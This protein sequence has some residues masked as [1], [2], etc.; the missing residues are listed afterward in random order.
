MKEATASVMARP[1]VFGAD[2]NRDDNG[3]RGCAM[4]DDISPSRGIG[5]A[6]PH[7]RLP[8]HWHSS[9]H[10]GYRTSRRTHTHPKHKSPGRRVRLPLGLALAPPAEADMVQTQ[11]LARMVRM[12]SL[13]PYSPTSTL[14]LR[15]DLQ[16][17]FSLS[18]NRSLTTFHS[19]GFVLHANVFSMTF[20]STV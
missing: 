12:A 10:T 13:R 7:H 14:P 6:S 8:K 4:P 9:T 16:S 11:P 2:L 3:L 18:T 1:R 17:L 15:S 5:Q 19:V 20:G